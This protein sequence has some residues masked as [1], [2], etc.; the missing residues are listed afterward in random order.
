[1]YYWQSIYCTI[2]N[3]MWKH[4]IIQQKVGRIQ[5]CYI[6]SIWL[7]TKAKIHYTSFPVLRSKS[8]FFEPMCLLLRTIATRKLSYRKDDHVMRPIYGCPANFRES[9]ST[10]MDTSQIFNVFFQSILW[11]CVQNLMFIALQAP[12]ILGCTQKIEH[13]LDT[14]TLLFLQIFNGLLFRWTLEC[15]GQIWIRSFTLSRDNRGY[16]KALGSPFIRPLSIFSKILKG[17]CS[18]GPFECAGQIWSP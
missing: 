13:F 12:E 1:M 10:P 3:V 8:S 18:D 9:L 2:N 4:V 6:G 14:P 11:M 7:S 15:T 17:F 16:L 5:L